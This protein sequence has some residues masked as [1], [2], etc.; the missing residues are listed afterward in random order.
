MGELAD[1]NKKTFEIVGS[2]DIR[3][4]NRQAT[5]RAVVLLSNDNFLFLNS[6]RKLIMRYFLS[7]YQH[8][9]PKYFFSLEKSDY[10]KGLFIRQKYGIPEN[11][12]IVTLHIRESGYKEYHGAKESPEG[13]FKNATPENYVASIKYLISEN[14]YVVRIGDKYMN[15]L[16]INH[17]QYIETPFKQYYSD[18]VDVYFVAN[19][20]FMIS[21]A[22]GPVNL[23]E[24]FNIPF[25]ATNFSANLYLRCWPQNMFLF[26]QYYSKKLKRELSYEE[27][28]LSPALYFT[29]K[30][31][32][33]EQDIEMIENTSEYILLATIEMH[34]RIEKK[35]SINN[36]NI[37]KLRNHL[38]I[39][40]RLA[41]LVQIPNNTFESFYIPILNF[42]NNNN[43]PF[44]V[45]YLNRHTDFLGHI[46][47]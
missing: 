19:S 45:E 43:F 39:K 27:I 44:C 23:A 26:K 5:V 30:A 15:R 4:E 46:W 25:L 17:P 28:L 36:D 32:S 11:A 21:S 29:T 20:K 14:Y 38:M 22:S 24:C 2:V 42:V 1:G 13:P 3:F 31:H 12:K 6:D 16:N 9:T 18:F 40:Q 47:S 35:L 37:I 10:Q 7:L 8:S 34:R 33:D 41:S